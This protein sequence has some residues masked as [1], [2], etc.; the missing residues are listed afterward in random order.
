LG[1]AGLSV[2]MPH[3]EDVA[4]AVDEL[5]PLAERLGAVNCVVNRD[6]TTIG[7]STDGI[8]LIEALKRG[9][10]TEPRGLR[11]A[12]IGAGGAARA[13]IA[14]LA[15]AGAAEVAV[16]NRT[17]SRATEAASLAGP[18]GRQGSVADIAAAQLVVHATPYGM[19]GSAS[20]LS[21][22]VGDPGLREWFRRG[23]VVMDL[24]YVPD[25]TPVLV[26]ASESGAMTVGGIGMLV[27]Q[28]AAQI[29][30]WTGMAAPVEVMWEAATAG[31]GT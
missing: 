1:I 23:Q 27:H 5:S 30:I 2:T 28:A 21:L 12:V 22:G 29:E 25:M 8:G 9:A 10:R 17:A 18:V 19:A 24:V 7:D 13:V 20:R 16:V 31:A 4:R 3:K 11:C 14:A 26:A 15:D 6:G